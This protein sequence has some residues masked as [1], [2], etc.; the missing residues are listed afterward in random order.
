MALKLIPPAEPDEKQA[1]ILRIKQLRRPDGLIQ[2]PRCG[3]R[4]VM[5]TVTGAFYR[6]GRKQGGTKTDENV[7]Y[8]CHMKGITTFMIPDLPRLARPK[9]KPV[10]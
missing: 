6:D 8:H 1:A 3:S 10:K 9:P 2:C 5:N 7:C 4:T